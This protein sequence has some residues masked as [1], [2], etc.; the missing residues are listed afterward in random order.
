MEESTDER[1]Q[2]PNWMHCSASAII[3]RMFDEIAFVQFACVDFAQQVS[4]LLSTWFTIQIFVHVSFQ[5]S[6]LVPF[7]RSNGQIDLHEL[8]GFELEI[9]QFRQMLFTRLIVGVAL[10]RLTVF[11][12]H[13][14]PLESLV[15][16]G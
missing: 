12:S 7:Q 4:M 14:L 13:A 8:D 16:F 1:S 5:S 2:C 9:D 6:I 10:V 11:N 3:G 15:D